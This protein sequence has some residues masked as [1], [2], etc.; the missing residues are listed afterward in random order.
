MLHEVS[1][2]GDSGE[3]ALRAVEERK[4]KREQADLQESLHKIHER[5]TLALND[6]ELSK[7]SVSSAVAAKTEAELITVDDPQVL[8]EVLTDARKRQNYQKASTL[9]IVEYE[10]RC[11]E[12]A[13]ILQQVEDFF[14]ENK[15][16]SASSKMLDEIQSE[17]V[18]VEDA[19]AGIEDALD[20]AKNASEKLSSLQTEMVRLLSIYAQFPDTKK[21]RKKLEKALMK[22]QEDVQH[23][24]DSLSTSAEELKRLEESRKDLKK[25]VEAKGI[26]V[27][28][29]KKEA[30]KVK[31]LTRANES[32][33]RDLED[34]KST[35]Q[36]TRGD[37]EA[38]K[39]VKMAPK[40]PS[41]PAVDVA[42]VKELEATVT[43][44]RQ[45]VDDQRSARQELQSQLESIE[46][47]HALKMSEVKKSYETEIHEMRETFQ[48]Q[49]K[50]LVDVDI[51]EEEH[52]AEEDTA[53]PPPSDGGGS[54][55]VS[56]PASPSKSTTEVV[57]PST[58]GVDEGVSPKEPAHERPEVDAPEEENRDGSGS[59]NPPSAAAL[60]SQ[61][62]SARS[63]RVSVHSSAQS[64]N[65]SALTIRQMETYTKEKID[66]LKQESSEKEKKLRDEMNDLRNRSKKAVAA[67][68]AQ[69]MEAQN[70]HA[71][72]MEDVRRSLVESEAA[73][74]EKEN[75]CQGLKVEVQ[76][77]RE[78]RS[79]VEQRLQETLAQLQDTREAV[80]SLQ[81]FV[82]T[83][84]AEPEVVAAKINELVSRSAQWSTPTVSR[85]ATHQDDYAS[86][87]MVMDGGGEESELQQ[88]GSAHRPWPDSAAMTSPGSKF[89]S[90]AHQGHPLFSDA[91]QYSPL[92]P[93]TTPPLVAMT[94][95]TP[96]II[97]MTPVFAMPHIAHGPV[98]L[99]D[100]SFQ[101]S[102]LQDSLDGEREGDSSQPIRR[103]RG[104]VGIA[105]AVVQL[106]REH[107]V[108]QEWVKAYNSVLQF[109]DH[110]A[111][112]VTEHFSRDL[113]SSLEEVD[114]VELHQGSEVQGQI[115]QMRCSLAL[116]LLQMEQVLQSALSQAAT[117]IPQDHAEGSTTEQHAAVEQNVQLKV[118][119]QSL[120]EQMAV[121]EKTH[122]LEIKRSQEAIS[123]LESTVTSLQKEVT[124][125]RRKAREQS[126]EAGEEI[127]MFTRLDS[128]RNSQN[129]KKALQRG[130]ITAREMEDLQQNMLDYVNLQGHRLSQ[131]VKGVQQQK[132]H[133]TMLAS[134]GDGENKERVQALRVRANSLHDGRKA[135]WSLEM[136]KLSL[137]R[138]K[139]ARSLTE[140]L[141]GVEASSGVFLI[142]P[143]LKTASP[144]TVPPPLMTP[145]HKPPSQHYAVMITGGTPQ[146]KTKPQVKVVRIVRPPGPAGTQDPRHEKMKLVE[147][148]LNQKKVRDSGTRHLGEAGVTGVTPPLRQQ[149]KKDQLVAQW[150][151]DMPHIPDYSTQPV[152]PKIVDLQ[153]SKLR[154]LPLSKQPNVGHAP[155]SSTLP[156]ISLPV[157]TP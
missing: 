42:K 2:F 87:P 123:Q 121:K 24:T 91:R 60:M 48:D 82:A 79:K 114:K 36:K 101:Q 14:T 27:T 23:L 58:E 152:F 137:Q 154:T 86:S 141:E 31:Q 143:I 71:M 15:A 51:D 117:V 29:L 12:R 38:L 50:S 132:A 84:R 65:L 45:E 92:S 108:V 67:L 113:V 151:V 68:R 4:K 66:K 70:R 56:Q 44:L 5:I 145:F 28:R 97:P 47:S 30:E 7:R 116:L 89:S 69:L 147:A 32:L 37:M 107:P 41:E 150:N 136:D 140:Q 104:Q 88:P 102:L 64:P 98:S 49:I 110:L 144:G 111:D 157:N 77:T 18:S 25:T 105:P 54:P 118:A 95:T 153:A 39:K 126:G 1:L 80:N 74:E 10:D 52:F 127:I 13:Q 124:L 100:S 115:T 75:V 61:P 130:N 72:E 134:L 21:G 62:H 53:S 122:K 40:P 43:A 93:T 35:L 156:P 22:A 133:Q 94:P 131:L 129:L 90:P 128:E 76:S 119:V 139:L 78:E 26:E 155:S 63:S 106:S 146:R 120:E 73:K 81:Q 125:L 135:R 57:E 46:E 83:Q 9:V 6:Y 8:Y 34:T 149:P 103:H 85:P 16:S 17:Q 96:P 142:K 109:K 99:S 138:E 3:Q 20:V 148:L 11:E 55:V 112:I 59:P 19:T 33:Q